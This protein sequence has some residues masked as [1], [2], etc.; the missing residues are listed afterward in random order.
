MKVSGVFAAA[1]AL[2][3]L[4]TLPASHAACDAKPKKQVKPKAI[5]SLLTSYRNGWKLTAEINDQD[6]KSTVYLVEYYNTERKQGFLRFKQDGQGDV[7]LYYLSDTSEM[8]VYQKG[9]CRVADVR[10]PPDPIKSLIHEWRNWRNNFTLFTILGPST[11]FAKAWMAQS[12]ELYYQ[13]PGEPIRGIKSLQWAACYPGDDDPTLVWFADPEWD[14]GYGTGKSLPLRIT[15]GRRTIDIMMMQPYQ[16][17][18]DDVLKIPTGLG[19]KRLAK[20]LPMPPNFSNLDL[21]FHVE[22]A[23]TNP[24][25]LGPDHY[26]SHLEVIRDDKDSI[27][28]VTGADWTSADTVIH[29]PIVSMQRIYDYGNGHAYMYVDS[30]GMY[31]CKV[32]AQDNVRPIIQL[33]DKSEINMMD[34][35]LPNYDVLKKASYLG[36]QTVR[37]MPVHTYELV[38]DPMPVGGAH[39][40]H[41][42]LIYSFLAEGPVMDSAVNQKNLPIRVAM[43]AYVSKKTEPYFYFFANI[44]DIT[45]EMRD[46]NK[47]LNVKNCYPENESEFTWVQLGFPVSKNMVLFIINR[48]NIKRRFMAEL[49]RITQLSPLRTPDVTI[50]FTENM[51]Y[52][53]VLVLGHPAISA[54]Y[55]EIQNKKIMEPDW[56]EGVI[57]QNDCLKTCSS[58]QY[59]DCSAISYCGSFCSTTTKKDV[60]SAGVLENSVECNTYVKTER[61][62]KRNVVL[63][64]DAIAAL[65]DSLLNSDFKFIVQHLG[66]SLA[67]AT[68]VAETIEYSTGGLRDV[69]GEK[70]PDLRHF[71]QQGLYLP[72]DFNEYGVGARLQTSASYGMHVGSFAAQDCADICRDREDCFAFSTCLVSKQCVISTEARKPT[73]QET[74]VQSDCTVFTKS[75]QSRFEELPG[76]CYSFAARKYVNVSQPAECAAMC[77]NEKE[78]VCKAFDFCTMSR[79]GKPVCR[80]QDKH[81]LEV[82]DPAD[83]DRSDA[84]KCSHYTR[85]HISDY[86]KDRLVRLL[87]TPRTVIKKVS[88]AECARQCWEASFRCD[89][90]DHCAGKRELGKGDCLLYDGDQGPYGTVM[91]PV[92]NSY[93]YTG[94]YDRPVGKA[95]SALHSNAKATGLSFFMIFLGA[96]VAVAALFAYGFYKTRQAGRG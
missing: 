5:P 34:T 37:G 31:G 36:I 23:F 93:T 39:L 57:T 40:T 26:L 42:V 20:D 84:E 12:K 21:E 32:E 52:I 41:A 62:R 72:K 69:I 10:N 87:G 74:E 95:P 2:V 86:R 89:R 56:S 65:E 8:F 94:N 96:G 13:G 60:E 71:H 16:S 45:T 49:Q 22:M 28:S 15:T 58:K 75:F 64:R 66:T 82:S 90:F 17:D 53:T 68:L 14:A 4:S 67:F 55:K 91:S 77:L 44:H 48:A 3:A 19:C 79:K 43:Y 59:K 47:K 38:T 35:I 24:S 80:L 54:D 70:D 85:K 92:C 30:S 1:L 50:D 88:E 73:H 9:S 6:E 25:V 33:P 27:L 76:I 78:F 81:I 11:L 83:L 46:L 63:T 29:S 18:D 51:V 61:S 7:N